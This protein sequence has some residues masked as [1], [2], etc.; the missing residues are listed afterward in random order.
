VY[1]APFPDLP[2]EKPLSELDKPMQNKLWDG[3]CGDNEFRRQHVLTVFKQ[4][5]EQAA[6]LAKE[7]VRPVTQ[8]QSQQVENWIK[9]LDDDS[10]DVRDTAGDELRKVAHEFEPLLSATTRKSAPGE[11]KNRLSRILTAMRDPE[12]PLQ[13]SA[14]LRSDL[15]GISLLKYLGT[16]DAKKALEG[17]A[18][19][20]AGTR[21]TDEASAALKEFG[22]K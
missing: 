22:R 18:E 11:I 3:L 4:H 7:K 16:E 14:A 21:V 6:Y 20:A 15:A 13:P 12:E 10:A 9:Q 2:R 19:G 1:L 8:K 17:L 5:A